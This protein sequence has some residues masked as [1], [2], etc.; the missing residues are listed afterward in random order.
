MASVTRNSAAHQTAVYIVAFIAFGFSAAVA[1]QTVTPLRFEVASVKPS[2]DRGTQDGTTF[3]VGGNFL[4]G[5]R[6]EARNSQLLTLIR[7]AYPDFSDTS[8]LWRIVGP[9]ELLEERFEVDGRAGRDVPENTVRLMLQQLLADRF[10]MAFHLEERP[11]DAYAL[12]REHPAGTLGPQM[13]PAKV[14]C[15]AIDTALAR[16]EIPIPQARV[17]GDPLDCGVSSG[18]RD[19][20]WR[21]YFGGRSIE[22]LRLLLQR[23]VGRRVLNRTALS[24][25]FDMELWWG[26]DPDD[27]KWPSLE[28]AVREQLG[29]RLQPAKTNVEFMVIDHIDRPTPD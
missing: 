2:R 5:G 3:I 16:G 7:R 6:F 24:G 18:T 11:V 20:T 17:P 19:G 28:T 26:I 12:V 9:T 25:T 4:P 10:K 29:L 13:R 1:Q 22:S 21:Y 8:E 23:S 14:D 27:S 15:R